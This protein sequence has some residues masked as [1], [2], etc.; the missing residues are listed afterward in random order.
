MENLCTTH[1]M[2]IAFMVRDIMTLDG[3][4][5]IFPL[6]GLIKLMVYLKMYH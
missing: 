6:T 4:F 2:V 3:I 1:P 5:S